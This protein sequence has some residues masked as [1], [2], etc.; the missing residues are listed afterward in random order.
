MSWCATGQPR[1]LR[2][3]SVKG[4]PVPP[5]LGTLLSASQGPGYQLCLP[6]GHQALPEAPA[7][8]PAV[9]GSRWGSRGDQAL[10]CF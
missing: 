9:L 7:Q 2:D 8:S 5:T 4:I 10:G 1:E 6:W 3:G